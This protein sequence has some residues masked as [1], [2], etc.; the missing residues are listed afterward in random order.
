MRIKKK[1]IMKF[2]GINSPSKRLGS[3]VRAEEAI[4]KA[5]NAIKSTPQAEDLKNRAPVKHKEEHMGYKKEFIKEFKKLSCCHNVYEAWND[6][7]TMFA[8][9]ISNS[10]DRRRRE[11]REGL[12]MSRIHKYADAAERN[13]F[14]K[15]SAIT[16]QALE[17][18][19]EQDFLG[20][21]YMSL[22]LANKANGQFFTP[23]H[24]SELM[25]EIT[26][27]KSHMSRLIKEQGYITI[28]DCCCGG[29]STLIAAVNT[30]RKR[31]AEEGLNFQNHVLIVAQ[32]I[33][34]TVALM[35]YIQISLLG[36]AGYVKVGNALTEPMVSGDTTENY[37]F[38]PMYFSDAW[39][40]RRL[41]RKIDDLM[42]GENED[43]TK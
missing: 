33:D 18:N 8:C 32:D 23:Y 35:C 11:E 19:P 6:F 3:Q 29:G 7:V 38:T 31:L 21:L 13:I 22:G 30:A 1:H 15:L 10:V 9:S 2:F 36:V 34:K 40:Y 14:P 5:A 43:G 4:K 12:Y 27:D 39:T 37:W 16:I 24:M 41:F 26:M 25:T 17:D 28:N 42:K 20:D